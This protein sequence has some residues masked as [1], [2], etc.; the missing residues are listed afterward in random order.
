MIYL[1][2]KYKDFS[3]LSPLS[4]KDAIWLWEAKAF[5]ELEKEKIKQ[6]ELKND[7]EFKHKLRAI[8]RTNTSA[9]S[10]WTGPNFPF[11]G[12]LWKN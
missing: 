10:L 8:T 6:D 11:S 9:K 4:M 1:C 7:Y 12:K 3:P 2:A 5:F